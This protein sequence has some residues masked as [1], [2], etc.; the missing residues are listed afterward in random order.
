MCEKH[1]LNK[2]QTIKMSLWTFLLFL[3]LCTFFCYVIGDWLYAWAV[4]K[5]LEEKLSCK[6]KETKHALTQVQQCDEETEVVLG[7]YIS[8]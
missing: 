8:D 7:G 4:K 3:F 2:F 6:K 1:N 5:A